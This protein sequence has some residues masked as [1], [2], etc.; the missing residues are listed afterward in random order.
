[1]T[2]TAGTKINLIIIIAIIIIKILVHQNATLLKKPL[3]RKPATINHMIKI[4][5]AIKPISR[6][7]PKNGQKCLME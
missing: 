4:H 2:K 1:M 7:I 5:R 6:F 3:K